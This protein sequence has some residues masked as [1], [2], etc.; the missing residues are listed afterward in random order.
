MYIVLNTMPNTEKD[1]GVL[2]NVHFPEQVIHFSIEGSSAWKHSCV[3]CKCSRLEQSSTS[4]QGC[5]GITLS[6]SKI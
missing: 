1:S 4:P 2:L 6:S 5:G 3:S